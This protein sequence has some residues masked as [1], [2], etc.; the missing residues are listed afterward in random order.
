MT[1][2]GLPRLYTLAEVAEATGF[3]L[4]G[5]EQDCRHGRV[6]HVHR[7]RDRLMTTAQVEALIASH[8]KDASPAPS[9]LEAYRA[10]AW[11]REARKLARRR[12]TA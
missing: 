1:L 11:Q 2:E 6:G 5:L 3:N 7:G 9:E 4:R 8:S 12:A 10:A